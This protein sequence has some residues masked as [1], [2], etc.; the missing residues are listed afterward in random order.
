MLG[1]ALA[2]LLW[3]ITSSPGL[4]VQVLAQ[5]QGHTNNLAACPASAKSG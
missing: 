3:S 1:A 4:S 5:S 2:S